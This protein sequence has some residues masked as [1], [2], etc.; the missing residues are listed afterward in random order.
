M[1]AIGFNQLI[2]AIKKEKG[3]SLLEYFY[4]YLLLITLQSL[5]DIFDKSEK[6]IGKK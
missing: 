5:K 4:Y 1:T 6:V 2:S 3:A